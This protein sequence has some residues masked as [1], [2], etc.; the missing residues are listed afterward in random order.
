[1]KKFNGSAYSWWE[2]SPF[3]SGSA[4]FCIVYSDGG[5]TYGGASNALGVAFGFCF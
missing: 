3:G 4:L 2:R 1:M 5:A